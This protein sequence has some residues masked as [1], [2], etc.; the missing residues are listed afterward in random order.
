M[1]QNMPDN[2]GEKCPK[3]GSTFF[4]EAEFRQYLGFGPAGGIHPPDSTR[5]VRICIC[6]HP[7][8]PAKA[9]RLDAP[10]ES[11][12]ESLRLAWE[13][14][15]RM[16]GDQILSDMEAAFVT[17]PEFQALDERLNGLG[18]ILEEATSQDPDPHLSAAG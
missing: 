6:G 15:Q 5:R 8:A 2:H 18:K 17:R 14:R 3:C 12:R 13:R 10:A 9:V 11:L 7:M 16:D 4:Q 1:T